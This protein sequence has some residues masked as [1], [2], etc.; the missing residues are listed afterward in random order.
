MSVCPGFY[1]DRRSCMRRRPEP[2]RQGYRPPQRVSVPE[3][4]VHEASDCDL[5]LRGEALHWWSERSAVEP[6]RDKQEAFGRTGFREVGSVATTRAW[7]VVTLRA[8]DR[9]VLGLRASVCPGEL[10]LAALYRGESRSGAYVFDDRPE[11]NCDTH[12]WGLASVLRKD[13]S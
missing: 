7:P 9:F 13:L 8:N 10:R 1:Y 4:A 6:V 5:R 12:R 2:V 11:A 3:A